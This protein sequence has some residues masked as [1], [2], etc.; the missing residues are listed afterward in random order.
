MLSLH[1]P[2]GLLHYEQC[3][4]SVY[5]IWCFDGKEQG[6]P[7]WICSC[8][9]G[10]KQKICKHVVGVQA[11]KGIYTL[12]DEEAKDLPIRAKRKRGRPKKV[13]ASALQVDDERFSDVSDVGEGDGY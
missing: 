9:V 12:Y 13:R 2:S 5:V 11:M 1:S 7:H 6:K 8:Y 3:K 4:S 10:L